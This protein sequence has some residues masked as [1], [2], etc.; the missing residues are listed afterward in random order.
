MGGEA[1]C[2]REVG[3]I[4]RACCCL[5]MCEEEQGGGEDESKSN[6]ENNFSDLSYWVYYYSPGGTIIFC[7]W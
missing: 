5:C 1:V 4:Y 3:G 6:A 7:N 2:W